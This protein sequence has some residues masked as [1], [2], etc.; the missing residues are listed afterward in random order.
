M[1]PNPVVFTFLVE[2]DLKI[3]AEKIVSFELF[4]IAGERVIFRERLT[5]PVELLER[6][7]LPAG[8][9]SY[10]FK[11]GP[12]LLKKGKILFVEF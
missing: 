9:Y 6:G 4:N 10:L 1:Y 12:E 11:S 2:V 7:H 5:N 3:L 8:V